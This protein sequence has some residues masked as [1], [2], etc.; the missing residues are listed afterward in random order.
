M[1]GL[2]GVPILSAVQVVAVDLGQEQGVAQIQPRVMEVQ[3]ARDTPPKQQPA[4]HTH[5]QVR[6]AGL[7][8]SPKYQII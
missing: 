3:I 2:P 6:Y 7:F 1:G 5:A 8:C 4:I